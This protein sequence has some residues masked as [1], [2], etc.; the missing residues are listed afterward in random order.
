MPTGVLMT[1]CKVA[2]FVF[3]NASLQLA[4]IWV[5]V[6]EEYRMMKGDILELFVVGAPELNQKATIDIDGQVT[7]P[8][9]G[10]LIAEG[11]PLSTFRRQSE[12]ALQ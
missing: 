3:A 5:A 9:I 12:R 11:V 4:T 10:E 6:A 7:L 1:F 2:L 8:L